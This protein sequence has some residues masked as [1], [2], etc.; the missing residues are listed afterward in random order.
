MDNKYGGMTVDERLYVSGLLREFDIA[1]KEKNVD[2]V[3]SILKQVELT[4]PNIDPIL[5][6]HGLKLE[7]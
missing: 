7:D 2:R 4:K 5:D 6:K 3:V 1:V